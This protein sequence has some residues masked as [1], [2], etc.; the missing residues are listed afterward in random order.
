[1]KGVKQ[2]FPKLRGESCVEIMGGRPDLEL[3][4]VKPLES[5]LLHLPFTG[6]VKRF[7]YDQQTTAAVP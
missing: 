2:R 7:R 6:W 1:M 4:R 5:I 3:G